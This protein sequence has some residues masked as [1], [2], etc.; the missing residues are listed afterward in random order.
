MTIDLGDVLAQ[1][2]ERD[3]DGRHIT[4]SPSEH[5]EFYYA[6]MKERCSASCVAW[7]D[8]ICGFEEPPRPSTT[9]TPLLTT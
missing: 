8:E 4:L 6:M 5:F 2:T 7:K 1:P 9:Q 3:V